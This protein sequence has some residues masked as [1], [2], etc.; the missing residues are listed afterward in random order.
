M[1]RL[2]NVNDTQIKNQKTKIQI[3]SS[4]MIFSYIK[5]EVQHYYIIIPLLFGVKPILFKINNY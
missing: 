5:Y 1:I 4:F 2:N 3:R